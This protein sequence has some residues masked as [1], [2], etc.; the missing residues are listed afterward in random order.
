MIQ[1][2]GCAPVSR[3]EKEDKTH[4]FAETENRMASKS[5]YY[6]DTVDDFQV[7]VTP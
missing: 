2:A 6:C 3:P 4:M 7:Y 1:S 5:I